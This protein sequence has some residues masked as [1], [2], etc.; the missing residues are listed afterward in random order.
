MKLNYAGA[1]TETNQRCVCLS[2]ENKRTGDIE[3]MTVFESEITA[4]IG[5]FALRNFIRTDEVGIGLLKV[6]TPVHRDT[7]PPP[8]QSSA[9]ARM[10]STLIPRSMLDRLELATRR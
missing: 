2:L 8:Q 4:N 6:P 9:G 7:R 5:S 3:M 1:A 10:R